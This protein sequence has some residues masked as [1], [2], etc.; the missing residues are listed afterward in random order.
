MQVKGRV[1]G[2]NTNEPLAY[3]DQDTQSLKTLQHLLPGVSMSSSLTL[4]RCGMMRN[5]KLC[6][7][8]RLTPR[9]LEKEC[10][11]WPTPQASDNR[12]RGN[13]SNP[14]IKRR[15]ES[16]KQLNLSMVVS[17]EPGCLNPR[18]V[19]WLMGVPLQWTNLDVLVTGKSRTAPISLESVFSEPKD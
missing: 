15:L 10:G 4:P 9:T 16:G 1:F 19:E 12:D 11:L 7:Q 14:C 2:K 3:Y 13:L 18:F 6:Q 5:G 8:Q 17:E